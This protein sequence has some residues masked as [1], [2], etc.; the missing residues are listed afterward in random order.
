MFVRSSGAGRV[1]DA[2][3]PADGHLRPSLGLILPRWS[4]AVAH[5][6]L[7]VDERWP[8]RIEL[9]P[10]VAHVRLDDLGLARVVPAPDAFEQ[11]RS[12]QDSALMAHEVGEQPEFRRG[13]L[14]WHAATVN[15][16]AI[17]V[18]F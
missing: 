10:Q 5:T 2:R 7:G 6:A 13:Q 1:S 9:A 3:S 14:D 16:P 8:Q 12:G 18:E 15:C 17:F 11:L 4:Q